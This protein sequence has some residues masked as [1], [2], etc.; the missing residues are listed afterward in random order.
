MQRLMYGRFRAPALHIDGLYSAAYM[1][2]LLE[3]LLTLLEL[4]LL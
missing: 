3:M 2:R 4:Y 1:A